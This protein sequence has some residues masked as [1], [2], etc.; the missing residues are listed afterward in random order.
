MLYCADVS[1]NIVYIQY[2]DKKLSSFDQ[3]WLSIT[4]VLQVTTPNYTTNWDD[5]WSVKSPS[6]SGVLDPN[7]SLTVASDVSL[8]IPPRSDPDVTQTTE[9]RLRNVSE[10]RDSRK[11][12]DDDVLSVSA[13][14][15][16][17]SSVIE[18]TPS[19]GQSCS[20]P[21]SDLRDDW[22][23]SNFL[24]TSL[25]L[26]PDSTRSLTAASDIT[27]ADGPIVDPETTL[28]TKQ[29]FRDFIHNED[30]DRIP[31]NEKDD[32]VRD[33]TPDWDNTFIPETP[34]GKED[35]T[36]NNRDDSWTFQDGSDIS[37]NLEPN[38]SLT[39]ASDITLVDSTDVSFNAALRN[40]GSAKKL[41]LDE[42]E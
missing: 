13:S 24:D 37:L 31:L 20:T 26:E 36:R 30:D 28:L 22:L 8:M 35:G 38:S 3:V 27:L 4:L 15:D 23:E 25:H 41:F 12:R 16:N 42:A 5:S 19:R 33:G 1:S 40:D 7:S 18:R 9:K 32:S 11:R 10:D 39:V 34:S 21:T 2:L 17:R 29:Q 6:S 14:W